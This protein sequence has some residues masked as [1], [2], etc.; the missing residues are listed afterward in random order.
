[1]SPQPRTTSQVH[2]SIVVA[3]SACV[4]ALSLLGA[5]RERPMTGPFGGAA[6]P[7]EPAAARGGNGGGGGAGDTVLVTG[8]DPDSATRDTTLDVTVSG[9]NFDAG[10]VV[11]WELNGEPTDSIRTNSTTYVSPKRL[12]ANITVA[13]D[14][15]LAQYDVT[16]TT[17][18]HG[19]GVGIELFTVKPKPA[20]GR[21]DITVDATFTT[22]GA[23]QGD[24]GGAYAGSVQFTSTDLNGRLDFDS[25]SRNG[26]HTRGL[27]VE[28]DPDSVVLA[29]GQ[30]LPSNGV[31]NGAFLFTAERETGLN[32]GAFDLLAVGQ[33]DIQ[34]GAINWYDGKT[35]W[36][37]RWDSEDPVTCGS[38]VDTSGQALVTGTEHP[39]GFG[40]GIHRDP[41][42]ADGRRVWT[43]APDSDG[44]GHVSAWLEKVP[45]NGP[46]TCVGK[47]LHAAFEIRVVEQ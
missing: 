39:L 25:G 10:S 18:R 37:L 34:G 27:D 33:Q 20:Y 43:V 26:K 1:M 17:V 42:T 7:S 16:V 13:A 8:V 41:D 35:R 9:D 40:I 28:L 46:R 29:A 30:A 11:G 3:L 44:A 19:R 15:P 6:T 12:V 32:H 47:V 24:G 2:A 36:I 38:A 31:Q 23:V 45:W 22:A 5:C 21:S 14:A 4:V